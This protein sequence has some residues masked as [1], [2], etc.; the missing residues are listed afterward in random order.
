MKQWLA[1][2]HL[3]LT[4]VIIVWD[5]MLAG[6]IAQLRQA[7]RAFAAVT[8]MAGLLLIPAFII[9][10]AT[11]TVITGRAIAAVDWIWPITVLLVAV[12]AVYA[13]SRRLVNPL[14]A[15]R[16]RSTTWCS[17]SPRSSASPRRM[18]WVCPDHF[19]S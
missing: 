8:G 15:I 10:L 16:S 3:A 18:A 1:P 4:L 13:A 14:W 6:R 17:R 12:Q 11:T 9:A 2:A 5:V 7:S 19:S